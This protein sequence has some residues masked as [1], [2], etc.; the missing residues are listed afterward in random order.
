M[1]TLLDSFMFDNETVRIFVDEQGEPWFV[2]KDVA[3][4]LEY[5]ESSIG[6]L[7]NLLQHIPDEWKGIMQINTPGGTQ[8]L[9]CLSEQC[10]YFFLGRSDKPKALPFQK[11]IAGEVMVSIRKNGGYSVR[12]SKLT[13]EEQAL[14]SQLPQ[15]L[16]REVLKG[17]ISVA[18]KHPE[19][20]PE[21]IAVIM[22]LALCLVPPKKPFIMQQARFAV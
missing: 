9:Y 6:Q 22:Q 3:T 1:S 4:A 7:T 12:G 11:W 2:A 19:Q 13:K 15:P 21:L 10:L 17:V 8:G 14:I 20:A 16:Q 5:S 18:I